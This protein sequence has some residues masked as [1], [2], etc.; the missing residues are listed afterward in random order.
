L[1]NPC[2]LCG[3]SAKVKRVLP[4][5]ANVRGLELLKFMMEDDPAFGKVLFPRDHGSAPGEAVDRRH[6]PQ[7]ARD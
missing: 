3:N 7:R 6:L 1:T 2:A 4:R 5:I